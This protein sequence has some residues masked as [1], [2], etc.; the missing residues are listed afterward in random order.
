MTD[1]L[2]RK[3]EAQRIG[4]GWFYSTELQD[5][6]EVLR[7][8]EVLHRPSRSNQGGRLYLTNKR[9]IYLPDRWSAILGDDRLEWPLESIEAFGMTREGGGVIFQSG[10]LLVFECLY[11][12]RGDERHL[13]STRLP[14]TDREWVAA[15][16]QATGRKAA[17][18]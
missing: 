7:E 15:L 18:A 3:Q 12:Q 8:A 2:P 10:Y 5:G 1:T 17:N 9:F 11:V 6:E 14:L 16:E 4:G 13:F